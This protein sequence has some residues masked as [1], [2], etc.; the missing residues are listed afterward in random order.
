[1]QPLPDTP[2]YN[3]WDVTLAGC[4]QEEDSLEITLAGYYFLWTTLSL[5]GEAWA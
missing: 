1:M 3:Q 5:R 2:Y 4:V